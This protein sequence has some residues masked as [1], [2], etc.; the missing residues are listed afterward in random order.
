MAKINP[1][2]RAYFSYFGRGFLI[3][4]GVLIIGGLILFS[5]FYGDRARDEETASPAGQQQQDQEAAPS[6]SSNTESPPATVQDNANMQDAPESQVSQAPGSGP[7]T[8]PNTGPEDYAWIAATLVLLAGWYWR[9]SK[10]QLFAK[11]L[12]S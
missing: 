7:Q 11:Q 5:Y 6:P 10:Q 3:I 4:L 12:G 2:I 9:K 8:V 1:D